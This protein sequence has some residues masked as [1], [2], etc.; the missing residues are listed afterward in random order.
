MTELG[1]QIAVARADLIICTA[2]RW[3]AAIAPPAV[4][5]LLVLLMVWVHRSHYGRAGA[6]RSTD[7]ELQVQREVGRNGL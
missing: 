1:I 3:L 5:F 2:L 7:D 4:L 6:A